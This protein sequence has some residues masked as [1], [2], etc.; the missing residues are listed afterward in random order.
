MRN[1]VEEHLL[2]I[3]RRQFFGKM[4]Q[5]IG[6]MALGSILNNNIFAAPTS[7]FESG[8]LGS[9]HFAPKAKRIIYLFQHGGPSQMDIFDYKPGLASQ[10]DKDLPKSVRGD[11]RIT[12]M[13]SGQSRLPIAPSIFQFKKYENNQDGL[14]VSELYPHTASVAKDLCV[15][16]SVFTEQINHDRQ[17][18]SEKLR[19]AV[20]EDLATLGLQVDTFKIQHVADEAGVVHRE[21]QA[22]LVQPHARL[23]RVPVRGRYG[24][25]IRGGGCG[26]PGQALAR[27]CE[28]KQRAACAG[29]GNAPNCGEARVY[30]GA[31]QRLVGRL[32]GTGAFGVSIFTLALTEI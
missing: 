26:R 24:R 10:F 17:E 20:R 4:A 28:R 29:V 15:V 25:G 11:Q 21:L 32:A 2:N 6:A 30:C 18:L 27:Q 22:Q 8:F 19:T 14:W 31:G 5:G 23:R 13:T 7:P 3:S 9:P 1:P 16:H 12:G